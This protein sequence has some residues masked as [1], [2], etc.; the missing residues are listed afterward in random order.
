[1]LIRCISVIHDTVAQ[2]VAI[3][4]SILLC[5]LRLEVNVNALQP[6]RCVLCL[7]FRYY[8]ALKVLL[9]Y[10]RAYDNYVGSGTQLFNE[11]NIFLFFLSCPVPEIYFR[12]EPRYKQLMIVIENLVQV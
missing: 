12:Q 5:Q 1:M 9:I 2:I 7:R 11:C 6:W 4:R 8:F 3:L 10:T